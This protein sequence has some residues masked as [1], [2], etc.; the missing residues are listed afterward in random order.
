MKKKNIQK[1]NCGKKQLMGKIT[2][3]KSVKNLTVGK[4]VKILTVG[5]YLSNF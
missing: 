1:N 4:P 2:V 3:G 5:I